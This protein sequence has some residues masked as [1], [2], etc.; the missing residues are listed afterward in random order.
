MNN[1]PLE[2]LDEVVVR[3]PM[4]TY[5]EGIYPEDV[6]SLLEDDFFMEA[7]Y[8]ASP[9]LYDE[10]VKLKKGDL[11]NSKEKTKLINSIYRYVTRMMTR[12]TPF[13]LFS[14]CGVTIWDDVLKDREG[15]GEVLSRHTR[16]DMHL[17][18]ALVISIIQL[19]DIQKCLKYYPNNSHYNIG[20]EVRYIEYS[21]KI[22]LRKYK[23]SGV[24]NNQHIAKVLK[25]SEI[26]LTKDEMIHIVCDESINQEQGE[27]FISD[28]INS[29]L[30]VSDFEVALSSRYDFSEQIKGHLQNFF[31]ASGSESIGAALKFF[32]E[33]VKDVQQLDKD[34]TNTVDA[35]KNII[36]KIKE[37]YPEIKESRP[38]HIDSY[39]SYEEFK[40]D[41]EIKTKL[42]HLLHYLKNLNAGAR[43]A[44]EDMELFKKKFLERYDSQA[45]LLVNVMDNDF[46]IGYPVNKRSNSAFLV[47]DIPFHVKVRDSNITID[48]REKW[49]LTVL[50]D[51]RN[52]DAY[53]IDLDKQKIHSYNDDESFRDIPATFSAMFRLVDSEL[54]TI[55]FEGFFGPS[56]ASVLG[57]FAHG[58]EEIEKIIG[59]VIVAEEE[60]LDNCILAEIVH[61]PDNRVTNII[62]HPPFRKYEIP[63]LA[64]KSV[65][66]HHAIGINDLFVRIES[67]EVI[68]FSK[69]LNKRVI[70]CKTHMHNH[71]ANSLPLYHFLGDLQNQGMNRSMNF[72]WGS[73]MQLFTFLPRVC[74]H[75]IIV[76][77]A[78]WFLSRDAFEHLKNSDSESIL[79][80]LDL[81]RVQLKLPSKVLYSEGDNEL[82]VDLSN[83]TSVEVWMTLIKD[84]P[85]ILL[86]EFLW[87]MDNKEIKYLNQY[88]AT[89]INKEKKEAYISTTTSV[90]NIDNLKVETKRE[91]SIGTEWL[92][93]KL[94]CGIGSVDMI[95]SKIISPLIK[96]I[97][98]H[99]LIEKWFYVKYRD[100]EFHVRL[101]FKLKG[102]SDTLKVLSILTDGINESEDHSLIWKIQP[103]TYI[104]EIE[105]YGINT[106]DLCESIFFIDSTVAIELLN[107]FI[108]DKNEVLKSLWSLRLV[109]EIFNICKFSLEQ[110]RSFV[111]IA[112]KGFHSEFGT[113]KN[114]MNS[115]NAK[116]AIYKDKIKDFMIEDIN[117]SYPRIAYLIKYKTMELNP[118][119]GE[120]MNLENCDKLEIGLF[121]LL[122]S[123]I[124][125]MLNRLITQKER[126]HELLI[127]E[128]LSKYYTTQSYLNKQSTSKE[129]GNNIDI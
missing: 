4:Y 54:K 76:S 37:H 106:I 104:R 58:N 10:C 107:I 72:S 50:K 123:I 30:L 117:T 63:Y 14:T 16:L 56:G 23:I 114:S 68:L 66:D 6:L 88:I 36:H 46:G 113:N 28:M 51:H 40:I 32:T 69:R 89:L 124:H 11:K 3:S 60:V 17:L 27:S 45:V 82:L 41:S 112:Q 74:Y 116:Y 52:K 99:D 125:M 126:V 95:L 21:Y 100:P 24:T 85:A 49:L 84:K 47:D 59:K 20:G 5:K 115:I 83:L 77:P 120:I 98:Q 108:N 57:R 13:G 129:K 111:E 91:F 12:S 119:L 8:V 122:S 121:H 73:L 105:R 110:K 92:Y 29:Q 65:D 26:G 87:S 81:L 31:V 128:F 15:S 43:D 109:D 93:V 18:N 80:E 102:F 90:S 127:Y 94:Y 25:N 96:I 103:E 67:N 42:L 70:P 33:I 34:V 2:F 97:A 53:V 22:G 79:V 38:F 75:N 44:S 9:L 61:M 118:L 101:R 71:H 35:Y 1:T 64:K 62:K 7:I 78:M 86:K 48:A 55:F 19:P 39:K